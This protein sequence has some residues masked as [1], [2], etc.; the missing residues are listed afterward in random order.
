MKLILFHISYLILVLIP[1]CGLSQYANCP[2]IPEKY[3]WVEK[4][5][6][7]QDREQIIR[8]LRWL[9]TSPPGWQLKQRSLANAYVLEWLAGTPEFSLVVQSDLVP[10]LDKF[11]DLLN[12]MMHGMAL[13]KLEHPDVNDSVKL[14]TEG[15]VVIAELA[16][17]SKELSSDREIRKIIKAHK[18][19]KLKA[20]VKARL[21][22]ST[23]K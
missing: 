16:I 19:H 18:R 9:C 3:A 17:Q 22:N 8:T 6:Y 4:E 21:S 14:H 10:S 20:Y 7:V 11:P 1:H 23:G 12:S 5:E 2:A 13:Y 15:L